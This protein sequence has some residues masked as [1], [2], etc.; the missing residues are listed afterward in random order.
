LAKTSEAGN[1]VTYVYTPGGN[2]LIRKDPTGSTLYL[3]GGTELHAY[4]GADKATGTRYYDFGGQAIA[5]RT[6]N[7][8]V[9]YLTAD[10]QGTAQI[11]INATTQ[12]ATIRRFTSFGTIRGFDENA[13]WPNDKG[14]LGATQ[15]P[16]GLTHL[17][18]REYNP[19][20]GRFI[21]VD[22]VINQADPQQMNGYTYANN[23]PVTY[24]DPTGLC[25][26][27]SCSADFAYTG[28]HKRAA[29]STGTNWSR[30]W[31]SGSSSTVR[32]VMSNPGNCSAASI[33]MG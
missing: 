25:P 31:S 27:N 33:Y 9:T 23:S 16:T 19:E 14:F 2:R 30:G 10:H 4:N 21:S 29:S 11:A 8:T 18:A 6:A 12:Q 5:M 22:P 7:G 13:T 26:G 3:P 1:D 17:G 28:P 20:T 15:D 24:S 32:R